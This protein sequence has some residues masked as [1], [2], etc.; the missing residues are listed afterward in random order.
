MAGLLPA[1]LGVTSLL[2]PDATFSLDTV[3]ALAA[4]AWGVAFIALGARTDDAESHVARRSHHVEAEH[5]VG[6]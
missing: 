5:L 1:A 4:V 3:W 6:N 2:Y